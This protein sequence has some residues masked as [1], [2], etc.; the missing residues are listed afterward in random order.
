MYQHQL[1]S[2]SGS[3]AI[4]AA[5]RRASSLVSPSTREFSLFGKDCVKGKFAVIGRIGFNGYSHICEL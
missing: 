4:L 2:K 5:I 3:L 1:N